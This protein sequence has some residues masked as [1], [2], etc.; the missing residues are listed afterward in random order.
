MDKALKKD[1]V[2]T[3]DTA[4]VKVQSLKV[5]KKKKKAKSLEKQ[6]SIFGWLFILPFLLGFVL[7]YLPMIISSL[8]ISFSA[9]EYE[10]VGQ[11][12][13]WVGLQNY[14]DA[15]G[16][17]SEFVQTLVECL[18]GMAFDIPAI[19]IFSL[20]M[21]ILLNQDMKGRAAFRAI[22]FVPVIVSTGII[23][24]IDLANQLSVLGESVTQLGSEGVEGT[25]NAG[26]EIINAIDVERFFGSMK[27]GA[28]LASVVSGWANNVYNIVN[29][30]GV[31]MLIFLAA[32][33]SISPSIYESCR[34]E[35]A[36]AWETFWKITFPMISPMI[37]VNLVYTII[38][39][40]TTKSNVMMSFISGQ[41]TE[42]NGKP[43]GTAMAW[44]Y[45]LVVIIIM[46]A[47]SGIASL[48]VFYQRRD[49]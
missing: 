27:I 2:L 21:A 19:I 23:E 38:D 4:S 3:N 34:V 22:F 25:V 39:S 6:K 18:G 26:T 1:Q 8:Q 28:E 42:P 41:L 40:F 46:A 31:Q 12:L 11:V 44:M 36:T 45:F 10:K 48:F 32:L 29:R 24:A 7:I 13:E 17:S 15:L 20:F 35:G 49:K 14:S 47:L 30:S 33:Q 43:A 37:L 16:D 9:I 5:N